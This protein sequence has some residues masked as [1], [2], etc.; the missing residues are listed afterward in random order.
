MLP[1]CVVLR[2]YHAENI[3][4]RGNNPLGLLDFQDA[5]IGSPLY[6]IVSIL[7]D[8]RCDVEPEL[9]DKAFSH[10]LTLNPNIN[11]DQA[12]IEYRILAAQR[13][14]RI[15]GVFARKSIR[16]NHHEYLQYIPR[17]LGYLKYD[18]G[19]YTTEGLQGFLKL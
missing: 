2:D 5:L 11:P 12:N 4:F 3:M 16:D 13:N 17:V 1:N 8:A 7:E 10:Y 19:H 9:R 15:L 14:F 18:L 6:D